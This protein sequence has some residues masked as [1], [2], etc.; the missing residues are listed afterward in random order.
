[1]KIKSI[2]PSQHNFQFCRF[3]RSL[4]VPCFSILLPHQCYLL[5]VEPPVHII[6]DVITSIFETRHFWCVHVNGVNSFFE[7][8]LFSRFQY[9]LLNTVNVSLGLCCLL[10]KF[11]FWRLICDMQVSYSKLHFFNETST[12]S[13]L[14]FWTFYRDSLCL[15]FTSVRN[16][17]LR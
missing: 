1:M 7:F 15:F 4:G 12:F 6:K 10:F 8:D 13:V 16:L 2:K 3:G 5:Y 9:S 17:I 14:S 11:V